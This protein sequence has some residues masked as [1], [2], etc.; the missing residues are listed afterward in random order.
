MLDVNDFYDGILEDL[1]SSIFGVRLAFY[2]EDL[3]KIN[4]IITELNKV[5]LRVFLQPMNVFSYNSNEMMELMAIANRFNV[6]SI[7]IV[8]SFGYYNLSIISQLIKLFNTELLNGISINIHLHNNQKQAL[9]NV[10][11]VLT[12]NIDRQLIIDCSIG[13]VGRGAGN[14]STESFIMLLNDIIKSDY[15][16]MPILSA[17][18][19]V[20]SKNLKM[21]RLVTEALFFLSSIFRLHPN[22]LTYIEYIEEFSFEQICNYLSSIPIQYLEDCTKSSALLFLEDS[23]YNR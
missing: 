23:I 3:K 17:S 2:K 4:L 19:S 13:G 1:S 16:V 12:S 20:L 6:Y 7:S 8:D 18:Y 9:T 21:P 14:V 22:Y 15:D 5:S 11:T 10:Y